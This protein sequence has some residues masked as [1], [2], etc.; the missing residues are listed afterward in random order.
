[1]TEQL[2]L[3][4]ET[5]EASRERF[6][7]DLAAIQS[8]WPQAKLVKHT[9]SG[10]ENLS[11][12]WIS[13]PALER[14]E[15]VFILTT[16][17]H[18]IE[19]Y[20]GSAMLQRFIEVFMP[21]LDP[22]NTGILFVH[23]INPWGMK[24]RRRVNANNVD[25]NRTFIWDANFDPTFNP[26]YDEI[27]LHSNMPGRIEDL[28]TS[29][30]IFYTEYAY[31]LATL[32]LKGYH[33][34]LLLGQYRHPK[35]VYYGGTG[36]QEETQVLMGLYRQ[37][38]KDYDQFLHLD[39]H[40]G[41]GPRYQMSLVNSVHEKRTSPVF[42]ERFD[43]PLVV[44][45]NPEEFYAVNGDM[46]DFVYEMWQH[47]CPEKRIFSTAFEFGTLGDDLYGTLHSPRALNQ[48]NRAYWYGTRTEKI[49]AQVKRDFEE[50]FNPSAPA[51]KMKAV[52]DGDRAFTG[53]LKAEGY[54]RE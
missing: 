39:M 21:R 12:D 31:L 18:G 19:G 52:A 42:V 17:E 53:I 3:F 38:M 27:N 8:L 49:L 50:L 5:Y 24:N 25:L 14:N 37:A 28:T 33:H 1:M 29:N 34:S 16:G 26:G 43:Y 32:G 35:G 30:W 13:S 7:T 51:W 10:D 46:V 6:R 20:V 23:A 47:E 41:Y 36:Y 15:K 40:T 11:I 4:P 44:A 45:A 9:L 22:K 48:E 2:D 54:I